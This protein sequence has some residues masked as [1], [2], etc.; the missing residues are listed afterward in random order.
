MFRVVLNISMPVAWLMPKIS[1]LRKRIY[2]VKLFIKNTYNSVI[3]NSQMFVIFSSIMIKR[4]FPIEISHDFMRFG[5][6]KKT[7]RIIE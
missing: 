3:K 2:E 1:R 4:E 5:D 6:E 7:S